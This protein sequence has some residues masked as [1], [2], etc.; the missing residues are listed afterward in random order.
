MSYRAIEYPMAGETYSHDEYGVYEYGEYE[1]WSV[2]AGQE[3][4]SFL[5][6]FPTLEA[7]RA[8]FP[9]AEYGAGSGYREVFIP[10]SP[11]EWFDPM[12]AGE[13]WGD[14]DY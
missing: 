2:L 7:A 14:E 11:P 10:Q 4:R 5:D 3:R 9:D 1:P 6:S 8:A 13:A 12:D